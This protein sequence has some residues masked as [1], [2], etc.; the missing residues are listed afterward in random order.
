MHRPTNIAIP[1]PLQPPPS[2]GIHSGLTPPAKSPSP[3]PPSTPPLLPFGGHLSPQN[4]HALSH[5]QAHDYSKTTVTSLILE[6]RLAPFYRGLEDWEEDYTEEDAGRILDQLR[7]K[8]CADGVQNSVTELMKADRESHAQNLGSVK[9]M[10]S[11]H[12][13][14]QARDRLQEERE[15][16]DRRE[17]R[18]YVGAM[19]CPICFLVRQASK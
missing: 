1:A 11:I 8:D 16:R 7:E 19:E 17:K 14:Q 9:K 18:A 3:E 4:P 12:K 5:P 6:G 15:Q 10:I 13:H 2:T